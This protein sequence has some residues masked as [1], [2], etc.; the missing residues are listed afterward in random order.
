MS[1][2]GTL[3]IAR[4]GIQAQQAAMRTVG[5]N[6]AN[7]NT[8]GYTRQRTVLNAQALG[9]VTVTGTER[10]RDAFLDVRLRE[11]SS[12]L[13]SRQTLASS[14][15]QIEASLGNGTDGGL[16]PAIR[17]FFSAWQD[18]STKSGGATERESV[19][20]QSRQLIASL[21][22]QTSELN[23]LRLSLD[24]QLEQQVDEVN[25]LSTQIA[26]LNGKISTLP[27]GMQ[28]EAHPEVNSLLDRRDEL[29]LQLSEIVPVRVVTA[30]NNSQ[31]IFMG[32]EVLIEHDQAKPLAMVADLA[33]N[34]LRDVTV[35]DIAGRSHSVRSN[36]SE[37]SLGAVME[38]RDDYAKQALQASEKLA[39]Q[40]MRDIN[41]VHRGG[42][43][44]DGVGGR[45]FFTGLAV[46]ANSTWTNRGTLA[47]TSTAVLN[48]AALT[49]EDYELRFTAAGTYDVVNAST[50]TTLSTGNAYVA[51]GNI[52]VAGMRVV[53]TGVGVA[54]DVIKFDSYTGTANRMALAP[55]V[56][57]DPK[58][59]AAGTTSAT[60]DNRNALAIIALSEQLRM[61]SPASATY[62][63]FADQV[64]L[65]IGAA[66]SAAQQGETDELSALQQV[67]SLVDSVSG[68]ST[69][70]EATGIIQ[71]QRAFEAS[72]RMVRA[73]D[74][75]LETLLGMV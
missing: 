36:L 47:A 72:S 62:E 2:F 14:L 41:A 68:V 15:Q 26:E 34:G 50:G 24:R 67:A 51:G 58:A 55:G 40:M 59:I 35:T 42:Q 21:Q 38:A 63:G 3:N 31:T 7:V 49:F 56:N 48:E 27:Q 53:L 57:A 17:E 65:R 1:I 71:F 30:S 75:M 5:N 20:Q 4:T 43:G 33:N 61:G 73:T 64:R 13:G 52:D 37:G 8:A 44:L 66:V 32:S 19:R 11:S 18:L 46:T 9:G 74:E 10:L 28:G 39:A 54:G 12:R 25:R 70:D 23:N 29:L 6:I 69:D 22:A 45:D 60:G 16:S